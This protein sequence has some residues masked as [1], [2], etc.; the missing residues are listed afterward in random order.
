MSRAGSMYNG[1]VSAAN[2]LQGFTFSG[3]NNVLRF[4][5]RDLASFGRND[6]TGNVHWK[7]PRRVNTLF[8]DRTELLDRIK[9]AMQDES[10]HDKVFV[11][12]GLGGLGKSEI[13][14]KIAYDFREE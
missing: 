14:L 13:C 2:A 3:G 5:S 12:M 9:D 11:I 6:E 1:D 8:T 7:V 4:A 10:Q